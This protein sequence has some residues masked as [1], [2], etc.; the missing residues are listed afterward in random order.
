MSRARKHRGS[1]ALAVG[2]GGLA[3]V[4]SNGGCLDFSAAARLCVEQGRCEGALPSPL[5][6]VGLARPPMGEALPVDGMPRVGLARPP[7]GEALP[8]DGRARV[9]DLQRHVQPDGGV[10]PYL[11]ALNPQG[12]E[13]IAPA[14]GLDAEVRLLPL[15]QGRAGLVFDWEPNRRYWIRRGRSYFEMDGPVLDLGHIPSGPRA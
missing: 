2:L 6:R 4:L 12:F 10:A 5:P 14:E 3:L 8:V 1:W 15:D 13:L 9:Q 7:V 11:R